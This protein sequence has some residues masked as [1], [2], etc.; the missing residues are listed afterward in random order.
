MG[1]QTTFESIDMTTIDNKFV[2]YMSNLPINYS[3]QY[4]H[5]ELML[6]KNKVMAVRKLIDIVLNELRDKGKT[7]HTIIEKNL[8]TYPKVYEL[9][10]ENMSL[11]NCQHRNES[12]DDMKYVMGHIA[13][14]T[15][16]GA[17]PDMFFQMVI[18]D[19]FR[20]YLEQDF[21]GTKPRDKKTLEQ[22]MG[23]EKK[24]GGQGHDKFL[25]PHH[26]Y[27]MTKFLIEGTDGSGWEVSSQKEASR[28][29]DA[30][31]KE[32]KYELIVESKAASDEELE[33]VQE[34]IQYDEKDMPKANTIIKHWRA[35]KW[36]TL[37]EFLYERS[38]SK[39]PTL[40]EH[41]RKN[42]KENWDS[43]LNLP[44]KLTSHTLPRL[45][46]MN[47]STKYDVSDFSSN[48]LD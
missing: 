7:E 34:S 29:V 17:P 32:R 18:A 4:S 25:P 9:F 2:Y 15:S 42:I 28:C 19:R 41:E 46:I 20:E 37:N 11:I 38:K 39:D 44:D 47:P 36:I 26:C 10:T 31:L 6:P 45:R 1:I 27:V 33:D 35:Y 43:K 12:P 13:K 21:N 16:L 40:D 5:K 48:K 22:I 8:K 3:W 30:Y 23:L 24:V 14:Q